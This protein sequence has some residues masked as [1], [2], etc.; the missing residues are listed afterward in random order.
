MAASAVQNPSVKAESK[1]A[2]KKKAKVVSTEVEAPAAAAPEATPS[3]GHA[4][5]NN[6]DGVYESPYIKELY[7]NIRA[8]NK[9]IA[10]AS[11]VDNIVAENSG[12]TLD[13]LVA[14]RKINRDQQVQLLKKPALQASLVQLE[15]Q[16]AQYKKFDAEYKSRSQAEK[17][18]FEKNFHERAATTS[19][20]HEEALAAA[21]IEGKATAVKEQEANL[22]LL[23]QFLKLAAIRRLDEDAA[24]TEENKALEGLLAQVYGGN[25]IAVEA[26]VNLIHGTEEPI[27]SV[28]GESL[29]VTYADIKA[30]ASAQSTDVEIQAAEEVPSVEADSHPVETDPTIANAALTEIDE[31]TTIALTNGP[32]DSY[33]NQGAPQ[34]SGFGDGAA[35]A[36]AEANWDN[37]N[38]LSTSQEWV[39]VPR[40]AA[41]TDTGL[42]ATPA[43]PSNVQSWADDQPESP[44]ENTTTPA[45]SQ[46]D[47]FQEIH[48]N[49]G[50]RGGFRGEG[51]GGR[52]RGDFRGGRGG[53]GFRGD[54]YR[55]RGR[56]GPRGGQGQRRGDDSV[57]SS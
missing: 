34:N 1:S 27:S 26:M 4:E 29:K 10:N 16:I 42:T 21:K 57:P 39:E 35:N 23:T 9:K 31:P 38:D 3:N 25:A 45:A 8:V 36:A 37:N 52:G 56:G 44:A 54:G 33:E 19:K 13:E 43:A 2:K 47:G 22:L 11:K 40:D 20:E 6:G 17:A 50:G 48:R 12:K 53:G 46:N 51:R 7:K 5:S 41:E 18:D 32:A 49:R 14:E 15:E 24:D 55:G 30:A 28:G